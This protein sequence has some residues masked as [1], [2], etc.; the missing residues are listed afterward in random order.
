[1]AFIQEDQSLV[2]IGKSTNL[3]VGL[4]NDCADTFVLAEGT[5]SCWQKEHL[6]AGRRNTFVLVKRTPHAGRKDTLC[7]APLIDTPAVLLN[8]LEVQYS[9]PC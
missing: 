1:M 6:R 2:L 4:D 5:P 3:P 8:T 9:H 7:A